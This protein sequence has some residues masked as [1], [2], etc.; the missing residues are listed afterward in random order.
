MA[1]QYLPEIVRGMNPVMD[2]TKETLSCISDVGSQVGNDK[3][4][5]VLYDEGDRKCYD[6]EL[7]ILIGAA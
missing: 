2:G 4:R 6:D 3:F 7:K 5:A 1:L